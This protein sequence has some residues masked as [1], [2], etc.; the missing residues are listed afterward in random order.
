MTSETLSSEGLVLE[1]ESGAAIEPGRLGIWLFLASECLFFAGLGSAWWVLRAG[2][3][4][5]PEA[6]RLDLRI[7][8]AFTALLLCAS[9]SA[10][11]AVRAARQ[12]ARARLVSWTLVTAH[13]GVLFLAG[14]AWEY[15]HLFAAGIAPRTDLAWGFFFVLTGA[16]GVHVLVGVLWSL[17]LAVQARRG[18]LPPW[19]A[20]YVEYGALY[21][22]FVDVVWL[23]LFGALY[24]LG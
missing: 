21:Q 19:R 2:D 8:L 22:H 24:L 20:R 13:F 6:S 15:N 17:G 9:F 14:Q 4:T 5:W 11:A 12:G 1:Y 10:G 23:A 18:A 3:S 16:H 7:G